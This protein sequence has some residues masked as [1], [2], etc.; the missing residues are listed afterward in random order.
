VSTDWN[1]DKLTNHL[2]VG[3]SVMTWHPDDSSLMDWVFVNEALCRMQGMT[4]AE[5]LSTPP[6]Q[7]VSREAKAQIDAFNAQLIAHGQCTAESVI[8]YQSHKPIPVIIHMKLIQQDDIDL[9]LAEFHDIR[10]F[11]AVEA[12]LNQAQDRARNIMMLIG[13]EKQ[14]ISENIQGNLGLVAIPLIDQLRITATDV[15][16]EIL[17]V[18]EN[19]I[20]H[21]TRKLGI[22]TESGL[23]GSN[24][25]RR[26]ILIC[27]M[28]R[29]GMTSKEIAT[30][31]GCS[32]STINNHR[33]AIRKKLGLSGESANLQAYLNSVPAGPE[34]P[35]PDHLDTILNDLV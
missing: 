25:T 5:I 30:V 28:I 26:Q 14:Q 32:P 3:L 7:Q 27:E 8:L 33:N 21:V 18:L 22:T 12:Q 24:L 9:L 16:M 35:D 4:R 1:L 23:P 13:R 31:I 6:Y 19:Q 15:Q 20:K 10:S 29:K 17:D 34:R 11:K 2:N